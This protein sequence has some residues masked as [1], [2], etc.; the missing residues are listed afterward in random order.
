MSTAES[1]I[2]EYYARFNHGDRPAFLALLTDDVIHDLNQG[3]REI[4]KAAFGK[5]LERMDRCYRERVADV[6]ICTSQDGQRAS[7]EYVVHGTYLAQDDGLPPATGQ[8]YVL[9]GG[10]FFDLR[11]GRIARV[12]NCY[13]LQN[14]LT[15]VG[16]T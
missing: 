14:W 3:R 13:N 5:F 11:D 12:T 2:T 1:L 6:R 10:A 8:R 4:G 16:A 7:A 9:P 15:Q